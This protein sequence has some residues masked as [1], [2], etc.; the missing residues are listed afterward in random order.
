MKKCFAFVISIWL[1]F[2]MSGCEKN[3]EQAPAITEGEFPFVLEYEMDG[4]KYLIEDAVVCAFD[5]YDL[6][7]PFPF[8]PY[9]RTWTQSLKSG[10]ESK[11]LF[12]EFDANI[13]SALVEGRINVESRIIL[14]YG[15]GG[16]Y[17]GDPEGADR[18]PCINYVE[19]YKTSEKVSHT[20]V[21]KLS[22]EQLEDLFAIK[23]IRF[24]FSQPIQNTFD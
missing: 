24:E 12:I 19:E 20:E 6:S 15:S 2:C 7:N 14:N 5:G 8:M 22:F 17:L 9:S 11:K 21:T 10:D 3:Y 4:Q 1:I 18:G 23:I 13:E 16:Y